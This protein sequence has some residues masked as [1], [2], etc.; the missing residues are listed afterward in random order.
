MKKY[1]VIPRIGHLLRALIKAANYR[2]PIVELRLDKDLDDLA[3]ESENRQSSS[4]DLLRTIEE[5]ISREL[6]KD[7]GHEWAQFFLKVW[8]RTRESL[9]TLV[10]EVDVCPLTVE[11]DSEF[12]MQAFEIPMLAGFANLAAVTR[13]GPEPVALLSAPLKTW[14]A[15]A[16]SRTG[17]PA[18]TLMT[19]LANEVDA[20]PRTVERWL[21]GEPVGKVAWP[22]APKVAA[23]IG[24]QVADS[25]L[26][27]LTGWLLVACTLQSLPST[28]RSAALEHLSSGRRQSWTLGSAMVTLR[29]RA[30]RQ[31]Q[32]P[33]RTDVVLSLTRIQEIFSSM[34]RDDR[35][36][37]DRFAEL[38]DAFC[39]FPALRRSYQHMHDWYAA[40]Q[41]ALVEE[42][43]S[44]LRLYASAVSAA[45]WC[46]GRN[47]QPILS[48]SLM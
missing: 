8:F 42:R 33:G 12:V 32:Q 15:Y 3:L 20:D 14:L 19:N 40:R 13:H 48:E 18:Q 17:I 38:D 10:Q 2:T 1:T 22:Y 47:L 24:R 6:A 41:A 39:R 5:T 4:C 27:H 34:P 29:Q 37:H 16:A 30:D 28:T 7:C 43:Q 44:A 9:Q 11:A 31:R 36:L 46:G 23:A 45:W 25:E 35:A 21:A 26:A